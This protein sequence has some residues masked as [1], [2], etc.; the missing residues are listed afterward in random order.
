MTPKV[1]VTGLDHIVLRCADVE[2]SLAFYVD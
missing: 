2:R 1:Q